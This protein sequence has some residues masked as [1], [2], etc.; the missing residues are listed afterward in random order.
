M[1]RRNEE[2]TDR[3]SLA[4]MEAS[5][6]V[7]AI[8]PQLSLRFYEGLNPKLME[9]AL[10]VIGEGRTYPLLYNDDI[11]VGSVEKA[12]EVSNEDATQYLP[13]GCGEY[14]IDHR[15]FGTPSGV[16]NLLK[17]LEITLHNGKDPLSGRQMGPET[18]EFENFLNFE[19]FYEAYKEQI[20]Y[21]TAALAKQ[22]ELEYKIIH[23]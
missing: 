22:E 12:F 20:R 15:S 8:E 11:N 14:I 1:G 9:K 21:F 2:N 5:R 23:I 16:I 4:A 3:F 18:G 10:D 13:F 7:L 6:V 19:D 17:A